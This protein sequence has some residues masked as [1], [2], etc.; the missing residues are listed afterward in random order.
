VKL[1][2]A[3]TLVSSLERS[4]NIEERWTSASPEFQIFHEENVRTKY[5]EA[6]DE[7][8]GLVVM[9]IFELA[10]MSVSGLGVYL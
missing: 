6:L 10:K 8:E 7:L 4:L 3:E 5:C 9:R 1:Q 2:N